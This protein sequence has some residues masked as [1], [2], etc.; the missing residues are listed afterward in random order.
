[1]G[2]GRRLARG[3]VGGRVCSR[4]RRSG[5]IARR[6]GGVVAV[7][8]DNNG[9]NLLGDNSACRATALVGAV[10]VDGSV[11]LALLAPAPAQKTGQNG[12]GNC[13]EDNTGNRSA[14]DVIVL[15]RVGIAD[16]GG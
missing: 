7:R 8:L 6:S 11:L 5:A 2:H 3:R 15:G 1:M 14:R 4:H 13:S 9:L 12:G 16:L 10:A